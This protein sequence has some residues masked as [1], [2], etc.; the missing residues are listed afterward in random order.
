VH[1]KESS[2]EVW[3]GSKGSLLKALIGLR[4]IAECRFSSIIEDPQR[5]V[6]MKWTRPLCGSAAMSQNDCKTSAIMEPQEAS[7]MPKLSVVGIDM[8]QQVFH[9]VGMD[10]QG[11]ILVRKR[12][13]R[14]QR[15]ACSAPL[16]PTLM[17][18]EACGGA[19]DGARR[20]REHGHEVQLRAPQ[21][22]KP[23]VQAN[24]NAR[25]DA[26][27][28]ADA[29][30]RPTM[31]FVATKNVGQQ[32]LQA[33]PRV[34]E[35]LMGERTAL[36]KEVH[37]L[38]AAYG[39]VLPTGVAKFRQAVIAKLA[40]A[41]DKLTPL[42]QEMFGKLVE[43]CV[44]LAKQLASYQE[45]RAALAMT[46]PACQRLRT[47]PG[48]GPLSATALVAAVSDASAFKNGRPCAAWLGR[49]P[50]Q[51]ATGGKERWVGI[52]KRGDSSL[53]TRLIHGA[54]VTL[55][56]VGLK[57]DRRSPWRRH[58]LARRGQNRPAVA[59]A[60]KNARIVWALLT[61]HQDSQPVQGS[62]RGRAWGRPALCR[63][64]GGGVPAM[65]EGKR[66]IHR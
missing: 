26:E 4:K 53:R 17:G 30:T 31:R 44:A 3:M 54:R 15:M 66:R 61:S 56:W 11:T 25:R 27:A 12:L 29:V 23:Y 39:M 42:S 65:R 60:N 22:V 34:R 64:T 38:M 6:V 36:V 33:L 52:S 28:I 58:W 48:I 51:H 19:H 43:A 45:Q 21:F 55:R 14:A 35:R 59:V 46:P 32:D 63:P 20:F 18:M 1:V 9:L 13:Y 24:K 2:V 49:V 40:T 37:G 16:P 57:T 8:A 7:P 5:P 41:P 50:R 10:E 47:I 62:S